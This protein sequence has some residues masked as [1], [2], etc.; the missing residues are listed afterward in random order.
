MNS[1]EIFK[2][3]YPKQMAEVM[4]ESFPFRYYRN[5]HSDV[6]LV[7]LVGGLGLSDLLAKHFEAFSQKYSVI[8]FDYPIDY[9]C[10]QSL[11]DAIAALMRK[12]EV[13]AYFVGQSLGGIIAQII[14]KN[15]PEVVEGLILSNTGTLSSELD[16]DGAQCFYDMLKRIDKSLFIMKFLPFG[17][18]KRR[19][20]KAVLNKTSDQLS[21]SEKEIMTELCDEMIVSLTKKYE[22]HMS[23]LLKDLQN[24][25]N[26]ERTDFAHLKGKV[27][28]I[29]SD[30][31]DTFNESVKNTLISIMPEP[32]VVTDILGGHLA[33]MLKFER[34]MQI[35]VQ[36]IKDQEE[37]DK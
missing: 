27:L 5:Q 34:Y 21:D 9:P 30:D 1:I 31:D 18:V 12:L 29:L 3:K 25:W 26:M 15:H 16:K 33:L 7:L 20:K 6:T 10:I 8:S 24:H 2:E 36:F 19:I 23:L 35:I 17:L 13:K 32:V 37:L 14:A 28:L 11:T 22:M 4:G